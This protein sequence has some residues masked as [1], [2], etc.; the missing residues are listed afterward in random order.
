MRK[1]LVKSMVIIIEARLHVLAELMSQLTF[2]RDSLMWL[3]P[4]PYPIL[5]GRPPV[6]SN[7][8]DYG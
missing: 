7:A 1:P 5:Q 6:G 2:G 4:S 3:Q 8:Q